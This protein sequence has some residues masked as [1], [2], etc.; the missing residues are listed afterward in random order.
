MRVEEGFRHLLRAL[1]SSRG[2]AEPDAEVECALRA[3]RTLAGERGVSLTTA[4]VTIYESAREA[5]RQ[6]ARDAARGVQSPAERERERAGEPPRFSCDRSLGGLARW[7]R[8]A[9][10]EAEAAPELPPH[11]LPEEALRRGLVLLTTDT[12][13]LE[14]RIVA[15]GS[16]RVVWLPSAL[17]VREKLGFVLRELRL[18]LR[19]PRCMTCGRL[20]SREKDSVRMRIP[21]RTA[22]WKDDYFVCAVCDQLFW[23]GTHWERISPRLQA[24]VAR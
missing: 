10:Y 6:T 8:A 11:R 3:A 2:I 14:R 15:D 5:A 1:A 21:P 9:G 17:T 23:Q 24:A 13:V 4:L 12:E 20:L 19:E 22:R 7:L 18:G 16:L